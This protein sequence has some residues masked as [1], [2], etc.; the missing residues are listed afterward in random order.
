[1]SII[2]RMAELLGPITS[3]NPRTPAPTE[4]GSIPELD[5]IERAV[6]ESKGRS[7]FPEARPA[8]PESRTSRTVQVDRDRLRKQSIITPDGERTPIAE[9]FRRIKRQILARAHNP[10]ASAPANLVMV[11]SALPGEGKTFCAINLAISIALEMDHNVLLV[12]ADVAK[13]NVLEVLGLNAE[14]GLIDLLRDRRIALADVMYKTDIG[15]LTLLPRGT[16]HK[17]ATELL[18]SGAM[19]ELLGEL[20]ER[21]RD[22]IVVFDSPPLLAASEAATLAGKMG[23]IV[24]VVEAGKTTQA[25]LKAALGHVD[26][27]K[28]AGLVLNKG[29]GPGLGYGD[30]GYGYGAE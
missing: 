26:S 25:A 21:Y 17:H 9:G 10:K 11:T 24:I 29:H 13:P 19:D 7:K 23:Q 12:D 30:Y 8:R 27:S 14:V 16:A 28:V 1:M 18:A 20:S 4:Q 2:E 6:S 22:R 15:K 5:A 3:P